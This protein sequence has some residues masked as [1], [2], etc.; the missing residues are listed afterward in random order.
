MTPLLALTL[1]ILTPTTPLA[2][3]NPTPT[4][5]EAPMAQGQGNTVSFPTGPPPI[6]RG[7]PTTRARIGMDASNPTVPPSRHGYP[8]PNNQNRITNTRPT[9]FTDTRT[10]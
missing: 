10:R 1:T 5:Q 2:T 8:S 4:T 6:R 9:T 3:I 7:A